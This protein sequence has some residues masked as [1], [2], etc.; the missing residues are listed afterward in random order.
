MAY[1]GMS[2]VKSKVVMSEE[3]NALM[4][5]SMEEVSGPF[6]SS[7]GGSG[8]SVGKEKRTSA[9]R[10]CGNFCIMHW[11]KRQRQVCWSEILSSREDI[12]F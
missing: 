5:E 10:R 4:T 6:Q 3:K 9:E 1:S 11:E 12:F 2:G 8:W 7:Q